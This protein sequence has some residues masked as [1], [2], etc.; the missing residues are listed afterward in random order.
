MNRPAVTCVIPVHN[1]EQY[2]H[3]ALESILAQT[4]P[5][6]EII[7]VDDGSTDATGDVVARFGRAV[8]YVVREHL[9]PS[10]AR[11]EALRLSTGELAAFLDADDWWH[12]EKLER[13]LAAMA[14]DPSVGLCFT[15]VQGVFDPTAVDDYDQTFVHRMSQPRG[16][17]CISTLL[18]R[19]SLAREHGG[20]DE[21]LRQGENME[22]FLRL[23][24]R[25]AEIGMVEE[26]LCYRRFH[27][28]NTSGR[29]E[30]SAEN[31]L[32][33]V[34]SWRRFNDGEL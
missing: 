4:R 24:A 1:G 9:G 26:P 22:W 15:H 19:V 11:N 13:Q 5:P 28:G 23:K 33:V 14:A 34:H 2:L 21:S 20:F 18:A 30:T 29:P 10:A 17:L 8:T 25:G 31:M 7:V 3:H 27:A 16:Y 32:N 12:P 6:D